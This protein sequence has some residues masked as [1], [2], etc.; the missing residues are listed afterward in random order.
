MLPDV[1]RAPHAPEMRAPGSAVAARDSA[2]H[3]W[4]TMPMRS[5][6]RPLLVLLGLTVL[7]RPAARIAAEAQTAAP[8]RG[9]TLR[10]VEPGEP[11][12]LD[13]ARTLANYSFIVGE[14]IFEGLFRWT[15]KGLVPWLAQDV[16]VSPDGKSWTLE[17]PPG[18]RVP[19]RHPVQR[20]GGE[21][22]PGAHPRRQGLHVRRPAGAARRDQ[23]GRRPH[24]PD[25]HEGA[26][27]TVPRPPRLHLLRDA[28]PDGAPEARRGLR[29]Q[30]GRHRTVPVPV[31]AARR[32]ADARCGTTPTGATRPSWTGSSSRRSRT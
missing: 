1:V 16:R 8:K 13:M 11:D 23:G 5:V 32:R 9:G 28:E 14:Q 26:V 30:P 29:K 19:R 18:R 3:A 25:H 17:A 20:G 27:R 7:T 2:S 22:Q 4:R 12:S 6:R 31:L 21:V 15:P 10:M 24:G